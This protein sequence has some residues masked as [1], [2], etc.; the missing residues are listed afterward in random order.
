MRRCDE[1]SVEPVQW[2]SVATTAFV[3]SGRW[4]W[5][6]Q[7]FW[8]LFIPAPPAFAFGAT[9]KSLRHRDYSIRL[10]PTFCTVPVLGGFCALALPTMVVVLRGGQGG[11]VPQQ[12]AIHLRMCLSFSALG[13]ALGRMTSQP[14]G[15][16]RQEDSIVLRPS[17]VYLAHLSSGMFAALPLLIPRSVRRQHLIEKPGLPWAQLPYRHFNL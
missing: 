7:G 10:D 6:H 17:K 5:K 13:L 4:P 8:S 15:R 9:E 14:W 16:R 2:R 12:T 1:S 11:W 3:G